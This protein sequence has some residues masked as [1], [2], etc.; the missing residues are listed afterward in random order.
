MFSRDNSYDSGIGVAS[1]V[2][3]GHA[4]KC[5]ENTSTAVT[6]FTNPP[7][8]SSP[9]TKSI[10]ITSACPLTC[11]LGLAGEFVDNYWFL[12]TLISWRDPISD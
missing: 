2:A 11:S 7:D 8:G 10:C 12:D 5:L 6:T 3:V 9:G 4:N 1:S